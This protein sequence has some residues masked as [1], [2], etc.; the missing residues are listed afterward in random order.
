MTD[1][2]RE[3]V[4]NRLP[5]KDSGWVPLGNVPAGFSLCDDYIHTANRIIHLHEQTSEASQQLFL[6]GAGYNGQDPR[7]PPNR[8]QRPALT[9]RRSQ[10]RAS[11]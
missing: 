9:S 4:L 6:L 1:Y 2:F 11:V 3:Y 8:S 5:G 10:D 7:L